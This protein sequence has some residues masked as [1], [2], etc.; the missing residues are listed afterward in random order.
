LTAPFPVT[1]LFDVMINQ[2]AF[3]AAVHLHPDVVVIFTVPVP[4]PEP[5][6]WLTGE[7]E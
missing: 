7:T 6:D 2:E 5:N 3:E 4:P 1:L